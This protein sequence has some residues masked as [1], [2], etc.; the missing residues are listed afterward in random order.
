MTLH[1]NRRALCLSWDELYQLGFTQV[2][3]SWPPPRRIAP[4][5]VRSLTS[6]L[7]EFRNGFHS[8]KQLPCRSRHLVA[9]LQ[10]PTR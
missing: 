6:P 2:Q 5:F 7:T 8:D 3:C 10:E 1:V 9:Y 4:G